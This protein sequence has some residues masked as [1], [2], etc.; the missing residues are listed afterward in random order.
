[1]VS[2]TSSDE[3]EIRDGSVEKATTSPPRYDSPPVDRQDRTRSRASPSLTPEP[4]YRRNDRESSERMRNAY[5]D[6][7]PAGSRRD[8]GDD[9]NDRPRGDSRRFKVRYEDDPPS[10]KRRSQLSYDDTD[11]GDGPNSDLP[12]DDRDRYPRKR[13]RTRSRSPY[14]HD[15]REDRDAYGLQSRGS[16]HRD[17]ADSNRP[18]SSQGREERS[19]DIK[20]LSVSNRGQNPLPADNARENAKLMQGSSQ[21]S[22]APPNESQGVERYTPFAPA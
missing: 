12:Y 13:L 2:S 22:S 20:D 11:R 17:S 1:M 9:Y 16:N 3:G 6:R 5:P 18:G 7:R 14:R 15:R 10:S 19:R 8:R 21:K 4:R